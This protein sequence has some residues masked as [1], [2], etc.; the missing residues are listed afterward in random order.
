V[1]AS[2]CLNSHSLLSRWRHSDA[3]FIVNVY[4][5]L[6][7]YPSSIE[8]VGTRVP[9]RSFS[10][11]MLLVFTAVSSHK[12]C[13]SSRQASAANTVCKGIYMYNVQNCLLGCTHIWNVGRQ[14]CSTSQKTILIIITAVRTWNLTVYL[15]IQETTGYTYFNHILYHKNI[16][17]PRGKANTETDFSLVLIICSATFSQDCLWSCCLIWQDHQQRS[18]SSWQ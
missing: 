14:L 3:V 6:K 2:D 9:V 5:G 16:R 15:Y 13:P 12:I 1:R 4:N 10:D 18:K 17:N 11:F 7:C 8:I